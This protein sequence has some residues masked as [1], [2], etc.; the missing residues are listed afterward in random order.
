MFDHAIVFVPASGSEPEL[1]G[2]TNQANIH[3]RVISPGWIMAAGRWL[4]KKRRTQEEV[5]D[6]QRHRFFTAKF[7]N[8]PWPNLDRRGIKQKTISRL[9]HASQSFVS[10]TP[11]MP[12]KYAKSAEVRQECVCLAKPSLDLFRAWRL[13]DLEKPFSLTFVTKG[14]RGTTDY[15]SAVMASHIEDLMDGFPATSPQSQRKKGRNSDAQSHKEAEACAPR[16]G[17]SIHSPMSMIDAAVG[18]CA[19]G[20]ASSG[21]TVDQI[22]AIADVSPRTFSRYFATKDA[23]RA[24]LIDDA[25]DLAAVELARQPSDISHFEA[26]R[27]CVCLDV[28]RHEVRATRSS[29]PPTG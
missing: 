24:G 25:I 18:I 4:L 2:S 12:K 8:S 19:T 5:S 21:T 11:A 20:R 23:M 15:E 6:L 14:K 27:R 13:W 28:Q 3:V 26:L 9:A 17:L 7:V 29:L 22:A 16:T 10:F 1:P